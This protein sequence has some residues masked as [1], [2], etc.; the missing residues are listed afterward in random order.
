VGDGAATHNSDT[1]ANT[2]AVNPIASALLATQLVGEPITFY[3]I[4]G[5]GAV[6]AGIWIATTGAPPN[7]C[8]VI[9][10]AT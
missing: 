4:G 1:V 3:L 2:T 7:N 10:Q 8:T 6:F 5:L 9:K